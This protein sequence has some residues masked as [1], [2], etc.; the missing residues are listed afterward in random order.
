MAR[1]SSLNCLSC[2]NPYQTPHSLNC[3]P[4]F[5]SKPLFFLTEKCHVASPSQKSVLKMR[6]VLDKRPCV[7][8]QDAKKPLGEPP[9]REEKSVHDHHRKNIFWGTFL[10]SKKNIPGRWIRKPYKNQESHIYHRNLSSVAPIVFGKEKFLTGA[11][12]CMLSFSQSER[13]TGP[14]RLLVQVPGSPKNP[15][16]P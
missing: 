10:A 15:T 7:P 8:R 12:R 14:R 2:R 3:L 5:H 11:G 4:P 9:N 6:V 16:F 1:T 13:Q